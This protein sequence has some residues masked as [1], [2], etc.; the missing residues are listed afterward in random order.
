MTPRLFERT[1]KS[2]ADQDGRLIIAIEHL[3]NHTKK[4]RISFNKATVKRYAIMSK[5]DSKE[6]KKEVE[7]KMVELTSEFPNLFKSFYLQQLQEP[8]ATF[9]GSIKLV[10]VAHS[11]DLHKT[12]DDIHEFYGYLEPKLIDMEVISEIFKSQQLIISCF[13]SW[14]NRNYRV[15]IIDKE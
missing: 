1:E 6:M 7:E 11:V 3:T 5:L 8:I 14:L 10:L 9:N 15:T 2:Y 13:E 4:Y 12:A